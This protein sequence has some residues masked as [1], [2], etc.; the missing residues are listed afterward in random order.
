MKTL[1]AILL[2]ALGIGATELCWANTEHITF[3]PDAYIYIIDSKSREYK[4]LETTNI[5]TMYKKGWKIENYLPDKYG[6]YILFSRE[7]KDSTE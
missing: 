5:R 6:L 7:E 2:L 1:I 4:I 3:N